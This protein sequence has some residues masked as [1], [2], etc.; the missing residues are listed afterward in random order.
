M[1]EDVVA[2]DGAP[3][4]LAR[5][6]RDDV[7]PPAEELATALLGS[8]GLLVPLSGWG[9]PQ[10]MFWPHPDRD[11]NLAGF[12]LTL[13]PA[14]VRGAGVGG[15]A[16]APAVRLRDLP[17]VQHVEDDADVVVTDLALDGAAHAVVLRAVIDPAAEPSTSVLVLDV[18]LADVVGPRRLVV[19]LE[20][21]L[22]GSARG[23]GTHVDPSGIL[24]AYRRD[25]VLALAVARH[26]VLLAPDVDPPGPQASS[27]R[28]RLKV[29]E[30]S[31]ATLVIALGHDV[32]AAVAAAQASVARGVDAVVAARRAADA[33]ASAGRT[34]TLVSGRLDVLDRVGLRVLRALQDPDGG[35]L[36]APESDPDMRRSGGYGFVWAR[37][38]AF[39]VTAAAVAGRR[40][41]VDGALGWLVRAQSRDGLY[42]QRHWSDGTPAPSWGL[43]LDETGAVLHAIGEVARVLD[44]AEVVARCWPTVR[45]GADALAGLL[46]PV[47]GLPPASLDAW[48]ER[49]GVHT[50]TVA[51]TI[52]GLEAAARLADGRDAGAAARWRDAARRC[53]A[54]LDAHLWS[55]EHGRFLR[56]RDVA[57]EDAAGAPVP[58]HHQPPGRAAHPVRSVDP[59]DPTVDA[60][61][62]GLAYPF[63]VLAPDDP[64]LVAT[65]D[66]VAGALRSGRGLLRYPGDTY[67]G[68][69]P[70]LLTRLWLGL[71]RR[72]PG[73][74]V[75]ADG[76]DDVAACATGAMLLPEQVDAVTGRPVWIV[77]L[78][79][80]HAF[81]ALACRPDHR[82]AD[83]PGPR[84]AGA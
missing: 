40:D 61:L 36:A 18:T 78:A 22:G 83:R 62:L 14:D 15:D 2:P 38:L 64:R 29:P 79:W 80:S 55:E 24:V 28:V 48:E 46:H 50:Y 34:P 59:V 57:R 51:A 9:E 4:D 74:A 84:P 31:T 71:A 7:R 77:P 53:R 63:A 12:S 20:L 72:A 8:G 67:V 42:E 37:D 56:S 58:E 68:G 66:A 73:A 10:Q 35:L 32:A 49:V 3:A 19:D 6:G 27:R 33:A 69:N 11:P 82:P 54:G 23:N 60:S 76:L 13:A 47:T 81:Y 43:Q 41:V 65:I 5:A 52:A 45:A 70:W 25:R 17:A 44:D 26:A 30:G 75:V 21:L 16:P 1:A 39:I